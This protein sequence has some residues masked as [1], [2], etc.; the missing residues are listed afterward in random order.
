ME[1][2]HAKLVVKHQQGNCI[3]DGILRP[4]WRTCHSP[5]SSVAKHSGQEILCKYTVID[6]INKIFR[7]R[8]ALN[9]HHRK[10]LHK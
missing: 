5:A 4:T 2:G 8:N 6:I 3:L 9:H 10:L 7:S 1:Y